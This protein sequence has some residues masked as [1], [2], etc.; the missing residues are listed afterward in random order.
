MALALEPFS[1]KGTLFDKTSAGAPGRPFSFQRLNQTI[2]EPPFTLLLEAREQDLDTSAA[3]VSMVIKRL[4]PI[5]FDRAQRSQKSKLR[6]ILLLLDETRRIR[7]FE[8]KDYITFAR[9]AQAGCVVVYQSL[10][11]IGERTKINVILENV[12]TQIYLGSL[13][14]N[15][16]RYF[17]DMLPK[18]P[19]P[20]DIVNRADG[21]MQSRMEPAD[22]FTTSELYELPGGKWPA[23]I[24]INGPGMRNLLLTDMDNTP[25]PP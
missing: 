8:A 19:R 23:L 9:E 6:P 18:R 1:R 10:D 12:G 17:I 22:Y 20:V 24:Y 4:Q 25:R 21:S 11:Q 2:D 14:G 7:N 3:V 15:T 5:L 16:A 13:V